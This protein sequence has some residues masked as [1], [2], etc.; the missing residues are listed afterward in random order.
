MEPMKFYLILLLL[1]SIELLLIVATIN[2]LKTPSQTVENL[3]V[4]SIFGF[5]SVGIGLG[6]FLSYYYPI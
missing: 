5:I 6:L 4:A 2:L 3:H 1:I